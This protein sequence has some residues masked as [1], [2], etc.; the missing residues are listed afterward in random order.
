MNR[1]F[2]KVFHSGHRV[3]APDLGFT[4]I[5]MLVVI[6]IIMTLITIA[7]PNYTDAQYRARVAR[8]MADMRTVSV[9]M[10]QYHIDWQMYPADQ[11]PKLGT[12]ENGLF[13]LT[14]PLTYLYEIPEDIFE[15]GNS[16]MEIEPTAGVID[17]WFELASTGVPPEL[18][19]EYRPVLQLYAIYSPGPDVQ[20]DFFNP[21]AWPY[22]G[23]ENPCPHRLGFVNY[24]ATNGTRSPGDIVRLGGEYK[25][26]LYCID[27]QQVSGGRTI[28]R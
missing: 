19:A 20:S 4:L 28:Y 23:E 13:Q 7:M 1:S 17:R 12:V 18:V 22:D 3:C 27:G 26:G 11:V 21:L 16:G 10:E 8:A 15:R 24:S 2:R 25:S 14:T 9:A 5:E 6:A